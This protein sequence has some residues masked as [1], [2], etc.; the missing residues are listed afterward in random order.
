[1]L[2]RGVF[3]KYYSVAKASE[4]ILNNYYETTETTKANLCVSRDCVYLSIIK[5]PTEVGFFS[6]IAT[7]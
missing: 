4:V 2:E 7:Y 3:I 1:M 5:K 6:S